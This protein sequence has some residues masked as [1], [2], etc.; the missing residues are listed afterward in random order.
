MKSLM[1]EPTGK[2]QSGRSE[3]RMLMGAKALQ[4][5]S[6]PASPQKGKRERRL[7]RHTG[8]KSLLKRG[9]N[10]KRPGRG[11]DDIHTYVPIKFNPDGWRNLTQQMIQTLPTKNTL[12]STLLLN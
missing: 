1:A 3:L 9:R 8:K 2:T 5:V 10:P 11:A 6:K 12:A 4:S 7:R